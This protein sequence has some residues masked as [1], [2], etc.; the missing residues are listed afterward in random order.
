M[1][2]SHNNEDPCQQGPNNF[3]RNNFSAVS[4][5]SSFLIRILSYSYLSRVG[6]R[7]TRYACTVQPAV[8]GQRR[9]RPDGGA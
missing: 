9:R 1:M 7:V 4:F 6:R 2:L 8:A 3:P 5:A